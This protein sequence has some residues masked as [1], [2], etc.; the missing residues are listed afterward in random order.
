[1]QQR[2]RFASRFPTL[3]EYGVIDAATGGK[4]LSGPLLI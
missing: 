4:L 2:L 1:L 3:V